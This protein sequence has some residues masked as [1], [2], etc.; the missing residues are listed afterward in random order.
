[1]CFGSA[2]L[3]KKTH[4]KIIQGDLFD[5]F[6]AFKAKNTQNGKILRAFGTRRGVM[7]VRSVA[8]S[9]QRVPST[10]RGMW[11]LFC[12]SEVPLLKPW[13]VVVEILKSRY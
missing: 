9:C 1:M 10:H 2:N 8:R 3:A 12:M 7:S 13:N 11:R 6:A 4:T 5:V